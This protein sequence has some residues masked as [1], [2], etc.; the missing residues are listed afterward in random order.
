M[1][2]TIAADLGRKMQPC[3]REDSDNEEPLLCILLSFP[4]FSSRPEKRSTEE[5]LHAQARVRAK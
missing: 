4:P 3:D 2:A 1:V 5:T